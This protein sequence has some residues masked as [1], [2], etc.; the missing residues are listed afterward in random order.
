MFPALRSS[1]NAAEYGELTMYRKASHVESRQA[2]PTDLTDAHWA[3]IEPLL[4]KPQGSGRRQKISLRL[5]INAILYLL[6]TGCQ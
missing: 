1:D 4:P 3:L 5:I 6:R 2:Y